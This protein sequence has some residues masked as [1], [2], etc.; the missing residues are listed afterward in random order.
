MEIN[1]GR[2]AMIGIFGFLAADA[3]PGAVP[4]LNSI[5]HPYDGNIMAPFQSDFSLF[6]S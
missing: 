3:V 6:G 1:N 5:A 2:L 4:A